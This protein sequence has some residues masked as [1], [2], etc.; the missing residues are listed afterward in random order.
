MAWNLEIVCARDPSLDVEAAV[1]DVFGPTD[2]RPRDGELVV[3]DLLREQTGLGFVT[4]LWDATYEGFA[5]D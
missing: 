3:Q 4:E 1:P 5:L 2:E